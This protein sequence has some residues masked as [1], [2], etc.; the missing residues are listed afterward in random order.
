MI[1]VGAKSR[2]ATQER[3]KIEE[4]DS[5]KIPYVRWKKNP[6]SGIR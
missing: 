3:T 4:K 1:N 5:E 6:K 2:R